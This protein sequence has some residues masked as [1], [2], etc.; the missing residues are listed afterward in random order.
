MATT[1]M[2]ELPANLCRLASC[3][4]VL[5]LPVEAP[6]TQKTVLDAVERHYPMLQGCLRDHATLRRR[7][8][9][10][11]FACG[12]DLSHTAMDEL[13]PAGVVEGREPFLIIGA[14]A[15]G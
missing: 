9:I 10:R 6:V 1:V 11:F 4:H 8:F 13:L 12:E 5:A 15:G 2:V 14:I 7:A 3:A